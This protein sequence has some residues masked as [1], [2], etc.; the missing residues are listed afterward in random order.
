MYSIIIII[1]YGQLHHVYGTSM[2][3][4][5]K[6]LFCKKKQTIFSIQHLSNS[7][8]FKSQQTEGYIKKMSLKGK[9]QS[10]VF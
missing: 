8:Y 4:V 6:D 7:S 1:I 9:K 5:S 3:K 10:M 2:V